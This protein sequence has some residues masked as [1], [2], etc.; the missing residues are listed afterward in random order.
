MNISYNNSSRPT[1][2]LRRKGSYIYIKYKK[3]YYSTPVSSI[4]EG[5]SK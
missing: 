5:I 4:N 2:A 1:E 3:E